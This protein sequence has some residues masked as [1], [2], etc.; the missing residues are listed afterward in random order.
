MFRI[1]S[2]VYGFVSVG[3]INLLEH[4]PYFDT[5]HPIVMGL[6][7][8]VVLVLTI[9]KLYYDIHKNKKGHK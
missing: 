4:I 7:E 6:L 9:I 1:A 3:V 8:V 5:I 2:K